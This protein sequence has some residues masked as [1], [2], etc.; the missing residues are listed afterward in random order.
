M[1]RRAMSKWVPYNEHDEFVRAMAQIEELE[2]RLEIEATE[3]RLKIWE[4]ER[5]L[6]ATTAAYEQLKDA[7]DVLVANTIGQDDDPTPDEEGEPAHGWSD[8]ARTVSPR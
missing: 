4:L 8:Y 6:S 7:V 2:F 3:A 5:K 1:G